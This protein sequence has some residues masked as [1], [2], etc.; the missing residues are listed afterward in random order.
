MALQE[1][2]LGQARENST[3]AV[4]VY[5]L[6]ADTTA[7]IKAVVLCNQTG[8]ATTF[9]LFLDNDGTTYDQTTALFYD[10]ALAA[11][12]TVVI[13]AFMAMSTASGH[14]AYRSGTANAV[15]I[16][17]FGAEIT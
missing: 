5:A 1:K 11:N 12:E 8:S 4:S 13:T 7:I 9:R 16:T 10:A 2:L 6:P 3:N 14:L 15:T 17:V